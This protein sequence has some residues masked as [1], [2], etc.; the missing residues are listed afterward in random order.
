MNFFMK[1][2][3]LSVHAVL[4]NTFVALLAVILFQAWFLAFMLNEVP[5]GYF[6]NFLVGMCRWDPGTLNLYQ[7]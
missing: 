6:R 5:W 7:S 2:V 4:R 3:L 1:V